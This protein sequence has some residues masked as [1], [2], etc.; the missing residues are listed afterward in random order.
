MKRCTPSVMKVVAWASVGTILAAATLVCAPASQAA[1][2][3]KPNIVFIL[4]D[5][6]GYGE[7]GCCGGGFRHT[8]GRLAVGV[9]AGRTGSKVALQ[10]RDKGHDKGEH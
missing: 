7:I 2:D 1:A 8:D 5:N 6:L 3:K 10:T 9:I 4:T